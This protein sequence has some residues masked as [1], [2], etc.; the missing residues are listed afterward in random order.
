MRL[1]FFRYFHQHLY[2]HIRVLYNV[3]RLLQNPTVALN[4]THNSL[5]FL[6]IL[7]RYFSLSASSFV[8]FN[9]MKY[10]R[11]TPK[12]KTYYNIHISFHM[13]I[14][15][16]IIRS[17]LEKRFF[18]ILA[19]YRYGAKNDF[20]NP[21]ITTLSNGVVYFCCEMKEEQYWEQYVT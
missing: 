12:S 21:I 4:G 8:L 11:A 6:H 7:I 9:Y 1:I 10:N 5:P 20:W 15:S 16:K 2:F 18:Y 19:V 17:V 13:T 3:F 14:E